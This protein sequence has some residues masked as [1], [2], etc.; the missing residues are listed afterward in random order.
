M[1]WT[2]VR[3]QSLAFKG[4]LFCHCVTP[5]MVD[6]DL[7]RHFMSPWLWPLT[8]PLRM[9]LLRS[10]A[11]GALSVIAGALKPQATSCFGRYMDG[12][13]QL[14]DLVIERMGDK[15]LAL[16]LVKDVL[17]GDGKREGNTL[18]NDTGKV[19]LLVTMA[20]LYRELAPQ[21]LYID[22]KSG[23]NPKKWAEAI[24]VTRTVYVGNMA[25]CTRE[26]QV[27]ALFSKCGNIKRV[28]MGLNRRDKYPCGFCFVEYYTHEEAEE[29]VNLLNKITFDDRVIRVDLDAGFTEGRQFGRGESGGQWRDDFREDVD[30]GRGGK[31]GGLLK[32]I[33]GM[34]NRQVYRGKKRQDH[35]RFA[36]TEQAKKARTEKAQGV[37]FWKLS[38]GLGGGVFLFRPYWVL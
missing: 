6:T 15:Q 36:T 21:V 20:H 12:E 23:Y 18:E 1:L 37:L 17:T 26:E 35:G 5:G 7:G 32:R 10:P 16:S 8:K 13:T 14:E 3:A 28:I 27:Y 25:F 9:V 38:D 33:E 11:E 34:P 2:S 22:K 24:K 30:E 19:P 29:A 4:G 31:G